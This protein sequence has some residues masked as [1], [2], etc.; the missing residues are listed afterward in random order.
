[1]KKLG[2]ADVMLRF[3][4]RVI[5]L[6][7]ALAG[8][9]GLASFLFG[10]RTVEAYATALIRIGVIVMFLAVF[11]GVGGYSARAGDAGAYSVSGAGNMSENL[12]HIADSAR[13]SLGCF[14]LLLL[15]GLGLIV[16][17]YLLPVVLV[18]FG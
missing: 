5:L 12:M 6:D 16:I 18:V 15:T 2:Y 7:A 17:G 4:G 14:F 1:M 9:V 10:W 11:I 3:I 8:V 13:S